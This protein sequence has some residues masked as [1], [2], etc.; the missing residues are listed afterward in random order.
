MRKRRPSD[1]DL[2][3]LMDG[4][5]VDAT[6]LINKRSNKGERAAGDHEASHYPSS[7]FVS[8]LRL[9]DSR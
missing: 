5:P 6:P 7:S 3:D 2:L 4:P 8:K 1:F 9:N